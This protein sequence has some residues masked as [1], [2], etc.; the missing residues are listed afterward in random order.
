MVPVTKGVIK[1]FL[2]EHGW[3]VNR[4]IRTGW[5]GPFDAS[6]CNVGLSLC[7]YQINQLGLDKAFLLKK[8]S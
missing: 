1:Q 4:N 5:K 2:K 7:A 8:K 6:P 3:I